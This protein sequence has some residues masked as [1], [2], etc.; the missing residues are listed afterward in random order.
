MGQV[1][2]PSWHKERPFS[3][4]RFTVFYPISLEWRHL[5]EGVGGFIRHAFPTTDVALT[6]TI[7]TVTSLKCFTLTGRLKSSFACSPRN[8]RSAISHVQKATVH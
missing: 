2:L 6:T 1:H 4:Y 5:G 7:S 3:G 8:S